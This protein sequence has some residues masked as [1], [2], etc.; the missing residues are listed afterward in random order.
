MLRYS[1][2]SFFSTADI[3]SPSSSCLSVNVFNRAIFERLVFKTLNNVADEAANYSIGVKK[4]AT[5]E[6]IIS[7]FQ[8]LY[9]QA[10][11]TPDTK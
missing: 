8:T 7:G 3:S 6:A 9:F 5:K 2:N 10:Q 4:Y 11:C 1:N